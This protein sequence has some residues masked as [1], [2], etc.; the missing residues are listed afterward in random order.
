MDYFADLSFLMADHRPDCNAWIDRRFD[1]FYALNFARSGRLRWADG[2]GRFIELTAPVLWWTWP[3]EHFI[4]GAMSGETWNH[5]YVTF[6]GPRAQRMVDTGLIRRDRQRAF[7]MVGDARR[8]GARF[9]QLIDLLH[10]SP[11]DSAKAAHLL[12]GLLL[13][14][15][16]PA[17]PV[18]PSPTDQAI[19]R[20][21]DRINE[22]PAR[23]Y[24][25][26]AEARRAHLSLIHFRRRFKALA[27]Q[28]P[29]QALLAARLDRAAELLRQTELS[30]KE[31]AFAVG[32]TD[33]SH[34]SKACARR[35]RMPPV[36]YRA[37]TRALGGLSGEAE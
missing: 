14:I 34:F 29:H 12:E 26:S 17:S 5:Y 20:L 1:G 33:L 2:R 31:I 9:D 13:A 16:E 28:S 32:Y 3:N 18:S 36:R 15:H 25:W 7:A 30:I 35:Y 6:T 19:Q 8:I 21:L 23:S 27:G 10:G 24:D 11:R 4:Y 22:N 37:E